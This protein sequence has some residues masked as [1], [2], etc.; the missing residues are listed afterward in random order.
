MKRCGLWVVLVFSGCS[1]LHASYV[2]ADRLTYEAVAPE[3][4]DYLEADTELS[5]DARERRLRTLNSWEA[6]VAAAEEALSE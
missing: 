1:G 5:V 2:N 3:Y 4:R 6:R